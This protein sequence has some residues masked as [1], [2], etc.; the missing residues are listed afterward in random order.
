MASITRVPAVTASLHA[1][2]PNRDGMGSVH[3]LYLGRTVAD[4]GLNEGC[5]VIERQLQ[6]GR[7]H[8]GCRGTWL[9]S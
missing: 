2:A 1:V 8:R 9:F 4:L 6:S 5:A 3:N 7:R